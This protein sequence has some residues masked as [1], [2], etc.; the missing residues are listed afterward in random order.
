MVLRRILSSRCGILRTLSCRIQC[1][2]L[3]AL[4]AVLLALLLRAW[5]QLCVAFNFLVL[6]HPL[7][8]EL[9]MNPPLPS[10]ISAFEPPS[11]LEFPVT[12][13]GG[14]VWIFSG[15]THLIK[16]SRQSLVKVIVEIRKVKYLSCVETFRDILI[17][18]DIVGCTGHVSNAWIFATF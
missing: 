14:G 1:S 8:K 4:L 6:P 15:T 10:E 13:R 5:D 7:G 3:L 11:S 17:L 2:V 9:P 18:C 12:F 16:A